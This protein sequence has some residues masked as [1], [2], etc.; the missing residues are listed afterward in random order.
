MF[1]KLAL[2]DI[3]YL[4]IDTVNLGIFKGFRDFL[5]L[6][7]SKLPGQPGTS[8]PDHSSKNRGRFRNLISKTTSGT[9][10]LI[11]SLRTQWVTLS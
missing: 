6:S 4:A 10:S 5:T 1:I 11:S 9:H 7:S 8:R 3:N 2:D